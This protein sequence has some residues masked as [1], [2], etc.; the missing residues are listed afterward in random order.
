MTKCT[1]QRNRDTG[2][3]AGKGGISE[4]ELS[5]VRVVLDSADMKGK[6]RPAVAGNSARAQT[7]M[8]SLPAKRSV[9]GGK[10]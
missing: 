7:K 6:V 5:G 8:Q 9:L 2:F 1:A 4:E 3:C 10:R